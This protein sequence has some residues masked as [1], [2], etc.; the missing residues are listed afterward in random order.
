MS[1][2]IAPAGGALVELDVAVAISVT[3]WFVTAELGEA[4]TAVV[5]AIVPG[6]AGVM[7]PVRAEL[8][9]ELEPAR[10][11]AV[12]STTI[13]CPTSAGVNVYVWPVAPAIFP[14]CSLSIRIP[15]KCCGRHR[16][17]PC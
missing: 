5:V 16:L 4:W 8:A 10:F 12:S 15:R 9:G 11:V 14:Q 17:P 3:V 13:V 2:A 1:K 7:T 6:G